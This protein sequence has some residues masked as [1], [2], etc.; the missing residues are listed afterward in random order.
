[1]VKIFF[2]DVTKLSKPVL[3]ETSACKSVLSIE[4]SQTGL[5]GMNRLSWLQSRWKRYD[6]KFAVI[7]V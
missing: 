6:E 7:S 5:G 2:I 3:Q 1:M 4:Y